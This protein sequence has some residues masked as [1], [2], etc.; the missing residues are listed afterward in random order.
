ML[1]KQQATTWTSDDP[2]LWSVSLDIK[3]TTLYRESEL[4]LA[5]FISWFSF[6]II[7]WDKQH[8]FKMLRPCPWARIHAPSQWETT[9]HCNIISHW[10]GAYKKL[11]PAWDLATWKVKIEPVTFCGWVVLQRKYME[12][13]RNHMVLGPFLVLLSLCNKSVGYVWVYVS[14]FFSQLSWELSDETYYVRHIEYTVGVWIHVLTDRSH[15]L[16]FMSYLS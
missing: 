1:F 13:I 9:L 14:G 15:E 3:C 11:I 10:L 7:F 2:D 12:Y 6:H 5:D 4:L 16:D 8:F